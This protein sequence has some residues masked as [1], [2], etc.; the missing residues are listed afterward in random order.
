VVFHGHDQRAG[1]RSTERTLLVRVPDDPRDLDR[2]APMAPSYAG[3]ARKPIERIRERSRRRRDTARLRDRIGHDDEVPWQEVIAKSTGDAREDDASGH[4]V[5]PKPVEG[6]ARGV[7]AEAC[8]AD[9]D[10]VPA[11]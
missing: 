2:R 4:V 9:P 8:V 11:P 10:L 7:R 5:F 6:R 3:L 1:K